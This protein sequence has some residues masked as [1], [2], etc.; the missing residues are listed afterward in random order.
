ML[1]ILFASSKTPSS[2]PIPGG[3]APIHKGDRAQHNLFKSI[4]SIEVIVDMKPVAFGVV[5]NLRLR[6]WKLRKLA[7]WEIYLM[8]LILQILLC[9]I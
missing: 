6:E 1:D 9:T 3:F 8:F 2:I 4:F 5:S 7:A